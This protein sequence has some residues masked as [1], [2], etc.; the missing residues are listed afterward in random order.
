M[1]V[2]R[3]RRPRIARAGKCALDLVTQTGASTLAGQ[4]SVVGFCIAVFLL[5]V[6]FVYVFLVHA[7]FYVNYFCVLFL[8]SIGGRPCLK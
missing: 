7:L 6:L 8:F 2:G 3:Q 4:F 5:L 1:A